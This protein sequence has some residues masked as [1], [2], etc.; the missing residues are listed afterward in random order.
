MT[1]WRE[2]V[3]RPCSLANVLMLTTPEDTCVTALDTTTQR[4]SSSRMSTSSDLG[5]GLPLG[6][7]TL[8]FSV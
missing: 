6:L 8:A 2:L 3:S 4:G 5:F 7:L 1:D